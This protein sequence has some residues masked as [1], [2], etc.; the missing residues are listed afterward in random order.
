MPKTKRLEIRLTAAELAELDAR[1]I[2]AGM[3]RSAY[4]RACAVE[5]QTAITA[6][7]IDPADMQELRTLSRRLAR[8]GGLINQTARALHR[9]RP[10]A[11]ASI[12]AEDEADD[13][14][15]LAAMLT[16]ARDSLLAVLAV[17]K[18]VDSY[19]RR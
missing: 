2:A 16:E 14:E 18:E 7:A 10:G 12:E 17:A 9:L 15:R 5:G 1:A 4:V 3:T 11:D 8:I 6:L 13:R 19:D